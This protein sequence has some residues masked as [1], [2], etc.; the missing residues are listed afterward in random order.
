MKRQSGVRQAILDA[1]LEEGRTRQ[2]ICTFLNTSESWL[3]RVI[4]GQIDPPVSKALRM[5]FLLNRPVEELFGDLLVMGMRSG[6]GRRP[7]VRRTA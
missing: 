5:A 7:Q 1:L 6:R 4:A 3:S 2:E